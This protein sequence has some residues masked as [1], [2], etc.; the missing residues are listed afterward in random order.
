MILRP[1]LREVGWWQR[2]LVSTREF[3]T[4]IARVGWL[5]VWSPIED[6]TLRIGGPRTGKTGE[7]ACRILDAPGAVIATSTRTD[8]ID[9]TGPSAPSGAVACVQPFRCGWVGFHDHVRPALGL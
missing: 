1:S 3:A 7:L 8:L 4:P 5:R 9:L 6:V 2:K